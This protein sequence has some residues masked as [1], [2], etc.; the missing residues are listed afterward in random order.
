MDIKVG[1]QSMRFAFCE[2]AQALQNALSIALSYDKTVL[3]SLSIREEIESLSEALIYIENVNKKLTDAKKGIIYRV[4]F[5][6]LNENTRATISVIT[7]QPL[8]MLSSY[9]NDFQAKNIILAQVDAFH[10][11]KMENHDYE[12]ARKMFIALSQ[13]IYSNIENQ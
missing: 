2:A 10:D 1:N 6:V 3:S 13:L 4:T 7:F 8:V 9:I 11:C 5:F 12:G